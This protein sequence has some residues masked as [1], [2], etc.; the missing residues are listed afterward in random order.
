MSDRTST[1]KS[2]TVWVF[3]GERSDFP[4]GIFSS[5]EKAEAWIQENQLTG[6]LTEYPI[7]E[8][9]Y[10]WSIKHEFFHPKR[11]EQKTP[12]FKG[13]FTSARQQHFHY[14]N[15]EIAVD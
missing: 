14:K 6:L 15:G 9:I 8:G 7:D 3:N 2:T 1:K 4:A 13:R 5:K 12:V 10:D 11:E